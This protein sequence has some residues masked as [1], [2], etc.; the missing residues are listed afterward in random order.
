HV[1]RGELWSDNLNEPTGKDYVLYVD[2]QLGSVKELDEALISP[3]SSYQGPKGLLVKVPYMQC[4]HDAT[5]Y[6][7][8]GRSCYSSMFHPCPKSAVLFS[9][10]CSLYPLASLILLA[11]SY[12]F[13]SYTDSETSA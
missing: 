12:F 11:P 8:G 1:D 10:P 7:V 3:S 5:E 9:S 13:S 4:V 6:V 2:A